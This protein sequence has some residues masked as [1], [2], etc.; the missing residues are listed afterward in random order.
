MKHL[1]RLLMLVLLPF[2]VL[3]CG[4]LNADDSQKDDGPN[5][6]QPISLTTK[7][8]GFVASGNAFAFRFLDKVDA[9]AKG[10][11]QDSWFVS[12]LSLQIAL[13]MLLNGAQGK[14]ADE[15]CQMLGY[16]AG[17]T[18]DVN[19]WSKLMLKELPKLDKK[20][21]LALADAIF[22]NKNISLKG[23]Y[24]QTV[25]DAYEAMIEA[26]DFSKTK[27]SAD[28][29]NNWCNEK[30][31][32]MI[33]HVLDEV[34]PSALAYLANALYFKSVW[35]E[36]FPKEGTANET[37][38]QE[39]G[40]TGKVKMMKMDGKKFSY[41]ENDSFQFVQLPYGNGAYAMTLF[42]P[43]SGHTV[44]EVVT[45]LAKDGRIPWGSR[46]EVDL[47]LPRFE[48]SYHILLN[49][50][51]QQLGMNTAFNGAM[52]DFSAMCDIPS[53]VSFVQQDAAIK[54]DEK[55][56]EAAAVTII[57]MEATALP[58]TPQ[59]VVFH[60]DHPFLYLITELSTGSILFAGKYAGQ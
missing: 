45:L 36:P 4:E 14:T 59:K 6:F 23:P 3:A 28:V 21:E 44:N 5:E 55:G 15:I 10:M 54:V 31:K 16:D 60:A 30:T 50:I 19:E 49:D 9:Y 7:Q 27:A 1:T 52:A 2:A 32:G 25:S 33:P 39:N 35:R 29:I 40:K 26:L 20:T 58:T 51:L 41:S 34:S 12:P 18:A 37:F 17:D 53:F 43:K 48:S 22:Y 24:R 8:S 56:T 47:W 46:A 38:T 57:G 13:G 42:L 11:G